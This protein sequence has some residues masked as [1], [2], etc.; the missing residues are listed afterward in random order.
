ML[1]TPA[2]FATAYGNVGSSIYYALGVTAVFAL[3]LTPLVFVDR[4]RRSSPP[5]PRPTPRGPCA[6]R[7]RAA[8]RASRATRSTSSSASAR[9]GRRCSNYVVTIA[10]SAFFVPH[11]LS[12]FWEPLRD[13][14]V[15]HRRRRD[16][17]R[18]AR[19]AEHRRRQGGGEA[20]HRPRGRRLRD[21]GAARAPRLRRS[22][23]AREVLV[24]NVH[25]GVAPTWANFAHR[26][27]GRD[28]R[29][30][31]IETISNL[32][33]EARDP[34]AQRPERVSS[35]SRSPCSRSTSRCRSIALSA[36]PVKEIDGELTTLLALPPEQGGFANDPVLGVVE[37]LGLARASLLELAAD[38][39]R[40]PRR[41]DPLH[42][43]ERRASSAPRGSPTRWRATG[44]CR[45]SSGGCTRASRRR[46]SRSSSSPGSRRSSSSCPGDV[47]LPRHD[48]LVR[49]DALV[50]DRA[51]VDRARCGRRPGRGA[52]LPRAA[53]PAARRRRLAAVRDLRRARDRRLVR[54]WSS[55]RTRR[56]AGSGSA[57]SSLGLVGYVVYRRR[58]VHAPLRETVNAPPAFGAGA[59]ARVPA[60]PRPDR[61]PAGRPTRRST[62]R[63]GW[64]PSAGARIVA[65][66]VIEV[67]LEL[68]LD[69]EL[70]ERG[71]A[72]ERRARRGAWRSATRTACG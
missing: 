28:D 19:R 54:S 60:D 14:P 34:R 59:R 62:S 70:P 67:P 71:A 3:G 46:G 2:L 47:E 56:R 41:D 66:T 58:C 26:D 11:Y 29:L 52:R 27:P 13:E 21:A 45:R 65:L 10:I 16:R 24:D 49:R 72:G 18:R 36:L 37:N 25:W 61:R 55:S 35:S 30:H 23:S 32:A 17:D 15:G 38:L 64:P 39:R 44:S 5:P 50:H 42:R 53:E 4:G 68:P 9:P 8:R 12:I 31:G 20:Q 7:R 48:V 51:R 22:S 63:A 33:E 69:A 6:S 43:H 57:G 1:G 40:H